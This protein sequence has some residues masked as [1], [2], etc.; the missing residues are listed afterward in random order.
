MNNSKFSI[1]VPIYNV[2]KYLD[3]CLKSIKEQTFK[4]FEVIMVDDGST[5]NSSDIAKKYVNEQFKYYHKKNGG[6]SSARNYGVQHATGQYI[7]FVDSDD[8]IATNTL[9]KLDIHINKHHNLDVIRYELC[10]VD[11]NHNLIS[12]YQSFSFSNKSADEAF[13]LL[14]KNIF[15][16]P[17]PL[18][19]INRKFYLNNEFSFAEKKLHEDFGLIPLILISAKKVSSIDFCGYYYVQRNGSIINNSNYNHTVK[20]VYDTLYH[21]DILYKKA[22]KVKTIS[23]NTLNVF[24]SYIS[25]ALISRGKLLNNKDLNKYIKELKSRNVSDLIV[26]DSISRKIKKIMIKINLK[27]Y[28]KLFVRS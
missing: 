28:I 15:V 5:D 6:L 7:M 27:L 25:N 21:F 17:A 18:Y 4:D 24:N 11:E 9:E 14:L 3:F 19:I 13:P 2:E 22:K 16:E 12:N 23:K 10:T 26:A 8:Y 1:I 20:K